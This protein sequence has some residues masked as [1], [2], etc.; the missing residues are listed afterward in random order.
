[1]LAR[2]DVTGQLLVRQASRLSNSRLV[3]VP[4]GE[5]P[6]VP[7]PVSDPLPC[8]RPCSAQPQGADRFPCSGRVTGHRFSGGFRRPPPLPLPPRYRRLRPNLDLPRGGRGWGWGAR[9]TTAEAVACY[10]APARGV[11]RLPVCAG[12]RQVA[13]TGRRGRNDQLPTPHQNAYAP[14]YSWAAPTHSCSGGRLLGVTR[15]KRCY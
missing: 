3:S 13:H 9:G 15:G 4:T 1:M 12:L 5:T 2:A 6:V 11:S 10:T 7:H 14:A 8:G